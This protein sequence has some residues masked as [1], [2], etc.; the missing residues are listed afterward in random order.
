MFGFH[1]LRKSNDQTQ[2]VIARGEFHRGPGGRTHFPADGDR[3]EK[4]VCLLF[5]CVREL[6]RVNYDLWMAVFLNKCSIMSR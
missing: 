6:I 1:Q 3:D 2:F 5:S 4:S